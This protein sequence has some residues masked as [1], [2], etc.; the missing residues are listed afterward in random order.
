[1]RML[2]SGKI[3]GY[4]GPNQASKFSVPAAV[5]AVVLRRAGGGGGRNRVRNR[6]V[7]KFICP[8]SVWYFL[9]GSVVLNLRVECLLYCLLLRMK[10]VMN[11]SFG[12]IKEINMHFTCALFFPRRLRPSC[13]SVVHALHSPSLI[14]IHHSKG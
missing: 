13:L 3:K 4:M 11:E 1:M 8:A 9:E 10:F 7:A 5:F 14:T 2:F 6:R 12:N